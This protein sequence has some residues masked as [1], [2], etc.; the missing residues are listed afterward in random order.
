MFCLE[1]GPDNWHE[2]VTGA[3]L[4]KS[5]NKLIWQEFMRLMSPRRAPG[6][7]SRHTT[8]VGQFLRN[9]NKRFIL[10]SA[11]LKAAAAQVIGTAQPLVLLT[12]SNNVDTVS[13]VKGSGQWPSYAV[14][15]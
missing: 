4:V 14:T 13:M 2:G 7:P 8:T 6:I 3:D 12:Y 9:A 10:T 11:F 5:A 1:Y 15:R